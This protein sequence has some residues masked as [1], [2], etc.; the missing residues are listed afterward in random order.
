[1]AHELTHVVQQSQNPSHIQRAQ[2]EFTNCSAAQLE[3]F[4]VIPEEGEFP[5]RP[6]G[7]D[8]EFDADGLLWSRRRPTQENPEAAD[9]E[10]FKVSGVCDL[11]VDCD[12]SSNAGFPVD[13]L[14]CFGAG[15]L[16]GGLGLGVE[17]ASRIRSGWRS[18]RDDWHN[19]LS[20][21][22]FLGTTR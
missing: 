21:N 2:I 17:G 16:L 3:E 1:M 18:G 12:H 20:N 6:T 13:G 9:W 22:P 11:V 10:W 19:A 14:D 8:V 7:N 4:A 15:F 5:F